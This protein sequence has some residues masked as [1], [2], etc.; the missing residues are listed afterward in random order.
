M[1]LQRA[2]LVAVAVAVACD[3]PARPTPI[4]VAAVAV[5]TTGGDLDLD[6]YHV[7]VDSGAPLT[8][9]TN[10]SALLIGLDVGDH[11]IGLSDVAANCNLAGPAHHAIHIDPLDTTAVNYAIDCVATG[12]RIA[13][14]TSGLDLDVDG[15]IVTVDSGTGQGIAANGVVTVTRLAPGPH[16]VQLDSAAANCAIAAPAAQQATLALG[17]VDSISFTVAC[18]TTSGVI[19]VAV[20]STGLDLDAN[21][22]SIALDS[23]GPLT[24][25]VNTT[26]LFPG[27]AAGVHT[28][29][30][31]GAAGNCSI[32]GAS[33][34]QLT[35]TTGTVVR[36]T[37]RTSF[38]V[39]CVATTGSIAVVAATAGTDLDP[40]GYTVAVDSGTARALGVNDTVWFDGVAAGDHSVQLGGAAV[41]CPVIPN[42]QTA[43]VTAGGATRDTTQ[44][45]FAIQCTPAPGIV[46]VSAVSSGVDFDQDGYTVQV[47]SQPP[48]AVAVNGTAAGIAVFGAGTHS[49]TLSGIATNCT[50]SAPNPRLVTIAAGG[51]AP[52]TAATTFTV[53]CATA[54]GSIAVSVATGG[55]DL[56]PDGYTV[57]VDNFCDYYYGCYYGWIDS[58]GV[59]DSVTFPVI[60]V[61][62][63]TVFLL[64]IIRN[65]NAAVNPVAVDV[66]PLGTA[67]AAFTVTCASPGTLQVTTTTTGVDLDADGYFI[68]V[69]GPGTDTSAVVPANGVM[70]IERLGSGTFHASV[71]GE[72]INCDLTSPRVDSTV[73]VVGQ[74]AT[75]GFALACTPVTSLAYV[76]ADSGDDEIFTINSNGTGAV[77]VSSNLVNEGDPVWSP[78]GTKIAFH[79]NRDGN[80]EIYVMNA[81]GSSPLRLTNQAAPD[82]SPTW[83]PDGS[84]IAFVS[85]RDGAPEIYVMDADGS[86]Q[87]RLTDDPVFVDLD[88]AWSPD[89]N[90]IAFVRATCDYV[91]SG[92]IYLMNPDGSGQTLLTTGLDGQPAW[93]PDGAQL[94]FSRVTAC[95]IYYCQRDLWLVNA[96]GTGLAEL[97]Q[98][99][100]DHSDPTWSPDGLQIAATSNPCDPY[101]GCFLDHAASSI[102]VVHKDGTRLAYLTSGFN[103]AWKP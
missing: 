52:D 8:I 10:G 100:N 12:F 60:P 29:T 61:G 89:G 27:L 87:V 99:Y 57:A 101:Y 53:T 79:S 76:F 95:G 3:D 18:T 41:N 47:D 14:L 33:T 83:S 25:S 54:P 19:A 30:L 59:N 86:N 88:P 45:A 77:R 103:P 34:R 1:R 43:T 26:T 35:L 2:V 69:T 55:V 49:V 92:S 80:A 48:V 37:A 93:S 38:Q 5:V 36:D 28:V 21:G 24:V 65:C 4:G 96:N 94:A 31:G 17:D 78:D 75:L 56:D 72:A 91:C 97:T 67:T 102:I 84:K 66:P 51:A 68:H 13:T 63:H 9:G 15:Y 16:V 74:T 64:D 73:V 50:V 11:D 82:R 39:T 58:V 6:G 85:E 81:D 71:A 7:S 23:L 44:V 40:N 32:G 62:P 98:E 22:Y 20:S 90:T 46:V 70:T 42:P